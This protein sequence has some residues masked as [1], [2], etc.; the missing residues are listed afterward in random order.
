MGNAGS[1]KEAANDL[2]TPVTTRFAPAKPVTPPTTTKAT[3]KKK[4]S[5]ADST[6]TAGEEVEPMSVGTDESFSS[7]S[8]GGR[9]KARS[10]FDSW[11][12]TKAGRKRAGDAM[13]EEGGASAGK[14]TRSA[15]VIESPA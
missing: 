7:A 3:R 11:Q 2:T 13:E 15:A 6:P 4:A 8:V 12:R 1:S 9:K 10:P 14:R 5:P